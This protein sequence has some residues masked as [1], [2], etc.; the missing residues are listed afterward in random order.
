MQEH[1]HD[2]IGRA[3]RLLDHVR[4]DRREN[5]EIYEQRNEDNRAALAELEEGQRAAEL[6]IETWQQLA[7]LLDQLISD[8]DA[9]DVMPEL[10][11]E[12]DT[13]G[14]GS[15]TDRHYVWLKPTSGVNR[16][17]MLANMRTL[18]RDASATLEAYRRAQRRIA[19]SIDDLRS[20]IN[21]N[22]DSTG[23]A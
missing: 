19:E 9:R 20:V 6:G 8:I 21:H 14:I 15:L 17:E 5:P 11:C 23:Q 18:M 1:D 22:A 7:D 10:P 4:R 13:I 12:L 16:D 2:V 3:Q